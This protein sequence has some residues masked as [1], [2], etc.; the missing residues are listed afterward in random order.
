MNA[1]QMK[2][3]ANLEAW[4]ERIMRCRSSGLS[5]NAWCRGNQVSASTY[6]RWEREIFGQIKK[7]DVAEAEDSI[8][9]KA[10]LPAPKHDLVEVPVAEPASPFLVRSE[11]TVFSPV[12]VIRNGQMEVSL[13]N[14][15][16]SKLIKQLKELIRDAE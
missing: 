8:Q 13:T 14:E 5:V 7:A 11:Q 16:S 1:N 15:V 2:H 9:S 3:A 4:K 12:A 10:L 6:Y